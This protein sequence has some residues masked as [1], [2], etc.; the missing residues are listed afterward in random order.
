MFR[1]RTILAFHHISHRFHP[2]INNIRPG[3]FF[4]IVDLLRD[5][6]Y[7]F[8]DGTDDAPGA[9]TPS[10][11]LTF[12]DGY[13]DL[14]DVL[15]ALRK[16]D[17]VPIVFVPTGYIGMPNRWEYSWRLF[18]ARHLDAAQIGRL[19]D[20]GVRF[21]SH[22]VSHR[23][24]AGMSEERLIREL[25]ESRAVLESISGQPVDLISFPFGRADAAAV[26]AA[27]NAGYRHGLVLTETIESPG[28]EDFVV[29]RIPVYNSDNYFSLKAKIAGN[30]ALERFKD[31]VIGYLAAGTII[32]GRELK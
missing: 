15:V 8:W 10:L 27:R 30:S 14:Y 31:G 19:A 13:C 17:I 18:P 1:G 21:G 9:S 25:T 6:G 2:G 16:K 24:L 28:I 32:I 26:A 20:L 4:A 29:A 12:D 23:C 5:W 22:G 7:H 11:I 3:N